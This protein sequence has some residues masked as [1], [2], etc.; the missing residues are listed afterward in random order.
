MNFKEFINKLQNLPDKQKKIILWTIVA[1]LGITMG[2]FWIQ[3][4][5]NSLSKIGNSI[6][7]IQ[8]PDIQTPG[9]DILQTTTPTNK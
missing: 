1:V 2:Y 6:G 7:Q 4:A 3:S 9:V 5:M 8:L